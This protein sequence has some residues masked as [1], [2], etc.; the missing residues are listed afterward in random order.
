[1]L[2]FP[3]DL[4]SAGIVDWSPERPFGDGGETL[5][6]VPRRNF[7][8]AGPYWTLLLD[9]LLMRGRNQILA[10]RA[11]QGA[12]LGG[13]PILV[14][15]C[16]CRQTPI[17]AGGSFGAAPASDGA[18]FDDVLGSESAPIVATCAA[19]ALRARSLTITFTGAHK[20]LVG[21][22][23][24]SINHSIWGPRM[25]PIEKV[26]GGT[27]DAPVVR[28]GVPLRQAVANGTALD[29]NRPGCVM[30]LAGAMDIAET[31]P[32]RVHQGRVTFVEL[33]RPIA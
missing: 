33:P 30:Q 21:G 27:V 6:G 24:F 5:G 32:H 26:T 22:E 15:P 23:R 3:R 19:A 28:L 12:L 16:D 10:G 25:Y 2:T 20:P 9:D 4:I 11:L 29:F 31:L 14:R 8:S 13:T 7:M 17:V 18:P 1:V